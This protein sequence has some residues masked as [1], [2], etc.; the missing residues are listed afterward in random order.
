MMG[1]SLKKKKTPPPR[2]RYESWDRVDH[3]GY[4]Q[5]VLHTWENEATFGGAFK[6][7]Q[8]SLPRCDVIGLQG[9]GP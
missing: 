8:P 5:P 4:I 2:L 9:C 7:G 1:N 3:E 6:L